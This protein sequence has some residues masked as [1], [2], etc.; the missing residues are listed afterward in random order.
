MT[1]LST[2]PSAELAPGVTV[3]A[4]RRCLSDTFRAAGLDTPELDARLL[5]GHALGLDHGALV[6]A[7][8]RRLDKADVVA[9]L[10]LAERRLN[11]EPVARILGRK[12][13]WGLPL[14]I[15]PATLVPRP[16]TETVVEAALAALDAGGPRTRTLRL[17]DLGTGSGALLLAL[18][19]ELP[20]AV[21][22]GTD[23]EAAA[24][25]IARQNAERLGLGGRARFV[26]CDFGKALGGGL[27]LVVSNPPYVATADI[28]T[29]APEVRYDPRRALDGGGDGLDCYRAI[30]GD[31]SRLLAPAG[32][33]VLELGYDQAASVTAIVQAAGLATR[34]ARHDLSGVP[35]ALTASVATLTP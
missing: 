28:E 18:L 34:P 8:V 27:D 32:V 10:A 9:L 14:D 31:A 25:T 17:A 20:A 4:A 2:R 22:I 29:L 12:E 13:F 33:L 6:A 26:V 19:S 23:V 1:A 7:A 11:R 24:L 30:V 15:G 5:A 3:D 35:R 16:E 21:G